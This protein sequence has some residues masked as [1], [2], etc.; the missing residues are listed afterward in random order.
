MMFEADYL[1][2]DVKSYFIFILEKKMS[3]LADSGLGN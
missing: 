1:I 2:F 3:R